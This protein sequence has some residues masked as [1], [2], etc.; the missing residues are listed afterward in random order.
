MRPI[1]IAEVFHDPKTGYFGVR[2]RFDGQKPHYV[3]AAYPTFPAALAA[4]DSHGERV[5]EEVSDADENKIL[6]SRSYR[7]G[8]VRD[9]S[10]RTPPHVSRP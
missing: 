7:P 5:W 10:S 1:P 8:S 6:I 4:C 3:L 2:Y 9:L